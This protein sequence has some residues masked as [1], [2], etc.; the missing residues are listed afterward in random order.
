MELSSLHGLTQVVDEA[1]R[2]GNTLDLCFTNNSSLIKAVSVIPG[3]S[4]HYAVIIDSVIKPEYQQ[5]KRR[6]LLQFKKANW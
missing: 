5:F 3:I 1:T 4:D 6:V 2:Q